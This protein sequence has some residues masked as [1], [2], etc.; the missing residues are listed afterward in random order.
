M[1]ARRGLCLETDILSVVRLWPSATPTMHLGPVVFLFEGFL[2]FFWGKRSLN[3]AA[4]GTR[5]NHFYDHAVNQIRGH[6]WLH[7]RGKSHS[8]IAG[9]R[10]KD[11]AS[12]SDH[13]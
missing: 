13:V 2:E 1:E 5:W 11:V 8:S 6:V 7:S 4:A 3:D 9:R 12:K 10:L